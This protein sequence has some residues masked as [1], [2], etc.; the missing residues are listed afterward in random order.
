MAR[1]ARQALGALGEQ[2]A[3]EALIRRGYRVLCRRY[4][5]R[6]GEIDIVAE[7]GQTLVFVEVKTRAGGAYGGAAV[8]VGPVKQRRVARMAED[9]LARHVRGERPCRFDV[10]AIDIGPDGAGVEVYTHA[11]ASS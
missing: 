3:F 10:V 5:T 1:D 6:L 4:R 8:A 11:F 2:L 7:D 9:Y